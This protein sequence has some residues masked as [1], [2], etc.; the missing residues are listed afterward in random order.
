MARTSTYQPPAERALEGIALRGLG[1]KFGITADDL[2]VIQ[3]VYANECDTPSEF[4]AFL[5]TCIARGLNPL[6]GELMAGR[7]DGRL[8]F[9]VSYHVLVHRA[10]LGGWTIESAPV[11]SDDEWGGFDAVKMRPVHHIQKMQE[12]RVVGAWATAAHSDGRRVGHFMRLA[13]CLGRPR[14]GFREG[15]SSE[16]E[17]LLAGGYGAKWKENPGSM[18]VKNA[19]AACARRVALDTEALYIREEFEGR[20][21]V[22]DVE[23]VTRDV[24]RDVADLFGEQRE[25]DPGEPEREARNEEPTPDSARA[26][27]P[28]GP[29]KQDLVQEMSSLAGRHG[30]ELARVV[31]S[32]TKEQN[33]DTARRHRALI[34]A[35][36][37]ADEDLELALGIAGQESDRPLDEQFEEAVEAIKQK[38]EMN[39]GEGTDDPGPDAAALDAGAD[40]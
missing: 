2:K 4:K 12:G 38:Q 36:L 6:R 19:V 16:W 21:L 7:A 30:Q 22:V 33:L 25:D 35:G 23:A 20:G 18:T 39:D 8:Q 37:V 3:S 32:R 31:A 13:E 15:Y 28:R 1:D 9:F 27:A 5:M 29:S 10:L 40:G 11:Y 14:K 26:G 24:P 34:L 17:C